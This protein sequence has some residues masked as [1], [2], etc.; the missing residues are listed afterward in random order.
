VLNDINHLEYQHEAG[1]GAEC[2]AASVYCGAHKPIPIYTLVT[3]TPKHI[4]AE[5]EKHRMLSSNSSSSRA[6]PLSKL[7]KQVREDPYT[8][9]DVR[10][11]QKGMQ[12]DERLAGLDLAG[13]QQ[14]WRNRAVRMADHAEHLFDTYGV[15][16]QHINRLL[17]P[18]AWQ[19]K[20][21]TA[22]E[23]DNFFALRLAPDAQPDIRI[24]AECM[25][26]AIDNATC[27]ERGAGDWHIPFE[28]DADRELSL[29]ERLAI[30]AARCARIS[31]VNHGRT[32]ISY[33][34]DM[35]LADMLIKQKH[36]TPLEH[37]AVPLTRYE[38]RSH[39][40][41]R[42]EMWSGNF[43]GWVQFRKMLEQ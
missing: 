10:K 42:G 16:K 21:I 18:F 38:D 9:F 22:T 30:S 37:Q 28:R 29:Y 3:R 13:F 4:D 25:R 20:V 43:R 11:S 39:V 41:R 31:Y 19:Y 24:A 7:T 14:S 8:P 32:D 33:E 26:E 27:I 35:E 34:K 23:W 40:D 36:L 6:I 15:H 2:I 1:I 17:E 12:G 5:I